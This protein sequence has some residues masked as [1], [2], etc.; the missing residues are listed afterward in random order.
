MH[1]LTYAGIERIAFESVAEPAIEAPTDVIMKVELAA[2]CGSDL[3]P[4]FGRERGP[5]RGTVMGHEAVGVIVEA[6]SAVRRLRPGDRV[7]TPF[8]TNCGECFYCRDG[9]TSRCLR[10]QL[11]GWVEGGQGCPGCRREYA[12]DPIGRLNAGPTARR[13][14]LR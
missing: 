9:L 6:G 12:R 10:G 5:G 4:Y 7:A 11:F 3:H 1:A 2:I 13:N 8:T 14:R